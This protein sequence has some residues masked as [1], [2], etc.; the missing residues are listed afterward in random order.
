M[1]ALLDAGFQRIGINLTTNFLHCDV[2]MDKPHPTMFKYQE[3][4]DTERTFRFL[5]HIQ[6]ERRR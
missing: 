3:Y 6:Y 4:Y 2:D 1:T 5:I